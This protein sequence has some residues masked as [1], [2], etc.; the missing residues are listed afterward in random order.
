MSEYF[1]ESFA[2]IYDSLF[3]D[4]NYDKE[5]TFL[6]Q[7]F[8]K[9]LRG[10]PVR[11]L[12]FG[13]GTGNH[14]LRLAKKGYEVVGVDLSNPML[15]RAREKALDQNLK[16]DFGNSFDGSESFDA[17]ISMFAVINYFHATAAL[18]HHLSQWYS[19]LKPK[20]ILII[21]TWNGIAVPF[22]YDPS[23]RKS[24]RWEQTPMQR[25]TL[26]ELDW[27]RQILKI[28][29]NIFK[30][31]V[32]SPWISETHSMYYYTPLQIEE[33]VEGVGF[34]VLEKLNDHYRPL[35][36]KDFQSLYVLRKK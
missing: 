1:N 25:E 31:T 10:K 7:V 26:S 28:N 22:F 35:Q 33:L 12:D 27:E 20:G 19:A 34:E 6:D 4:K 29:I 32:N 14:S 3:Q 13:C 15:K 18:K 24:F 8:Q 2:Q 9:Y 5:V 16:I 23:R 30:D 11:L 17:I 36:M 21:E